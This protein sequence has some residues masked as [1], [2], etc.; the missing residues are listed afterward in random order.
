MRSEYRSPFEMNKPFEGASTTIG[1]IGRFATRSGATAPIIAA[2]L[3]AVALALTPQA[4]LAFICGNVGAGG[5]GIDG[6]SQANTA[7]GE[8]ADAS[9]FAG[10]NTATGLQANA[11]GVESAN[12]ATGTNAD[13]SGNGSRNLATGNLAN[14]SGD[15]TANV[16]LGAS[17]VSTGG[18]ST[19]LGTFASATF[20]GS[21]ALGASATTTRSGQ[22][23]IG[24]GFNTY[25][26]P[27]LTSGLSTA[28]QSGPTALVTTDAA[29]NL[30][31]DGGSTFAS[32]AAN[33]RDIR[34]N[35]EGIAMAMAMDAPY[36]PLSSTFAMSGRYGNF[37]GAS[38]VSLSGAVRVSPAVQIDAGLA[39]GVNHNNL[40]GTVGITMNW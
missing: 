31:S 3:A 12:T 1:M 19:A 2:L 35:K 6:G 8:G 7:C 30:A 33:G 14:A 9:G 17:S 40:G 32:I 21:T 36:V 22:V 23:M 27:G 28:A 11:S 15:N 29:G 26:L 16:A 39:Y 13:A 37:E 38:A 34:R 20:D 5:V 18:L 10:L 25:T 24:T 4:S